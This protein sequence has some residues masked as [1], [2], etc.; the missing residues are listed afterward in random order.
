VREVPWWAVVSSVAAPVF[1]I[2]GWTLA[3]AVQPA[4]YLPTRDTISALAGHAASHRWL[5][6]LALIGLGTC[7]LVTALGLRPAAPGGRI[8]LALGGLATLGVAA[9]PLP[10]TGSS[11]VHGVAAAAAFFLLAVWPAWAAST[12]AGVPW[13]LRQPVAAVATTVLLGLVAWFVVGL[14]QQSLVGLA[15]RFAAGAQACWPLVAVASAW[16][17]ERG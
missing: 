2:G 6:T 7:H 11:I 4:G 9:F 3:A 8:L 10:R 12:G 17:A 1:L 15:E 13:A 16:L 14:A 5:M